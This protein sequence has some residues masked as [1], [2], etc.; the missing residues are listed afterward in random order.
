MRRGYPDWMLLRRGDEWNE[1]LAGLGFYGRSAT[2]PAVVIAY[3]PGDEL[4]RI[5]PADPD[6]ARPDGIHIVTFNL[7][8]PPLATDSAPVLKPGNGWSGPTPQPA[9]VGSP[10][11]DG[12]DAKAVAR[13]DVV[14]YQIFSDVIEVGVVAFHM[15][16][17]DRVDFSV[18]GGPWVSVHE[19]SLNPRTGVVEYWAKLD[20]ADFAEDGPVELRAIAWPNIGEPRVLAG[21]ID[22]STH[23]LGE[24][25]VWM[26]VEHAGVAHSTWHV[27]PNGS[28][29]GDGSA[30]R[31][32]R[33]VA[34]AMEASAAG[35]VILLTEAGKYELGTPNKH[36]VPRM[37]AG[38]A[39][40]VKAA[41]GLRPEEVVLAQPT[42][43]FFRP[44]TRM[45]WEGVSFDSALLSQYYF[46]EPWFDKCVFFDSEGWMTDTP[47]SPPVR[48]PYF[49][50]RSVATDKVY[51][52]PS[53]TLLRDV[54]MSKISGDAFQACALV[55]NSR[56]TDMDGSLLDHH[57]DV[58]QT[59]GQTENYLY[60]GLIA[61]NL[62][63]TQ[64][65][66][67][68]PTFQSTPGSPIYWM[69][70]CAFVNVGIMTD[71]VFWSDGTPR[72]GTP[73]SQLMSRFDH[74]I[75]R[76]LD[77]P[78]QR[79]IIRDD[80]TSNQTFVAKNL[81]FEYSRIFPATH[82]LYVTDGKAP[83]GVIFRNVIPSSGF[84]VDL[85]QI[86]TD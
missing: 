41:P 52:F 21:P 3:G 79:L 86:P 43:S 1:G 56:L 81:I 84:E 13:W 74:V 36:K 60:Y 47:A 30:A 17:I 19:M 34:R 42:R 51:G 24:F 18:N 12:Y 7:D 4:P 73:Y 64:A 58:L 29:S 61:D 63:E 45:R 23:K 44:E 68:E 57:T 32:F 28:D 53:A 49:V 15:N 72:G 76:G 2:E 39:L 55:I 16:G 83:N 69:T 85:V 27:S 78:N 54:T 37:E 80:I 11:D 70:D 46:G 14:P 59:F 77:L 8:L 5:R 65:M 35:D 10:S 9:P 20:P 31:P 50:T 6:D 67:L 40:H 82:K 66:F 38:Y 75:F 22:D 48:G 26:T 33:T 25:S 62:R 71:P